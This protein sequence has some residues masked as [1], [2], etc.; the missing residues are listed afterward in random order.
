MEYLVAALALLF[1]TGYAVLIAVNIEKGKTIAKQWKAEEDAAKEA[2]KEGAPADPSPAA[3]TAEPEAPA[4]TK[5]KSSTDAKQALDELQRLAE[6]RDQK[7]IT[8]KEFNAMKKRI[9]QGE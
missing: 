9:I 3:A 5:T 4:A 2:E 8:D 1:A 7:I 6:M